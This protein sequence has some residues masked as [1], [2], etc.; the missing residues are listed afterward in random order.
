MALSTPPQEPCMIHRFLNSSRTTF[1][2]SDF[3]RSYLG[4][5][6]ARYA[7][8]SARPHRIAGTARGIDLR[9]SGEF[10]SDR[11]EAKLLLIR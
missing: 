11:R 1:S 6:A 8:N 9:P 5:D 4:E 7:M 10:L 2:L 3:E